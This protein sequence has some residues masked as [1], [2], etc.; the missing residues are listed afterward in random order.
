MAEI[1]LRAP[2]PS[3][4]PALSRPASSYRPLRTF[5]L[6]AEKHYQ[7]QYSDIYFLRL[8]KLKPAV[9]R[10]AIEAWQHL[11]IAGEAVRRV[12]RVLDVRQGELCWVAGTVYME[13]GLKP[14]VLED[15]AKEHWM[16]VPP[17]RAKYLRSAASPRDPDEGAGA[18][19]E[20][21]D[22]MMLEDE[23]GRVRLLM[24]GAVAGR[25]RLV[26]GCVIA[27]MGTENAQGD[28]EVLDL[29]LPELAPQPRRWAR[30]RGR[31]GRRGRGRGRERG[32]GAPPP[33]PKSAGHATATA[34]ATA[35]AERAPGRRSQKVAIVSGLGISGGDDGAAAAESTMK[36]ELLM[37]YLLGEAGG[38]AEQAA[39][40]QIS[41]L[42]IAGNSLA[43]TTTTPLAASATSAVAVKKAAKKYG[44][45]AAA[46]NPAPTAHLDALLAR[47]LPTLPVTLIPGASDPANV[48]IPQQPIHHA[49]FPHSRAY[50]AAAVVPP[51]V[52]DEAEPAPAWF[53]AATNP[54]QGDVQGWRWLGTG[55]Q[56]LDDVFKYVDEGD[57]AGPGVDR[58]EMMER[59]LRWRCIAPTAP[60]TLWCY[61]FQTDEPFVLTECPHVFFAGN[62]PRFETVLLPPPEEEDDDEEDDDE[63]E[64]EEEAADEDGEKEMEMEKEGGEEEEEEDEDDT[65]HDVSPGVRLIAVPSFQHTGL[66]VLV[67]LRSLEV[68]LLR[69]EVGGR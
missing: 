39:S 55:G 29:R 42:I 17:G 62:Q 33:P 69:F 21:E 40:A 32:R 30:E 4:I 31:E 14:N 52:V 37:E 65:D 18:G 45:D 44:Y 46:Y 19:P 9:E 43:D 25:E 64:G 54:W 58:V 35:T 5:T 16:S 12:D 11:E 1:L 61:P 50:A 59:M 13:M 2:S 57:H 34:T 63:E 26:T 15:I 28:F 47:L 48:S 22:Q 53:D 60:D 36:I 41:R 67:D 8:A 23:S 38:A 3:P 27:V 56:V 51:D 20:D 24:G 6:P 68:E 49:L 10:H 66:V 7:Q